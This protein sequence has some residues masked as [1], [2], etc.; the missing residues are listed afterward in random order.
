M[1]H[2]PHVLDDAFLAEHR[3]EGNA[4][5]AIYRRLQRTARSRH[6]LVLNF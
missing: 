1:A 5:L 3:P 4:T 6:W 2:R